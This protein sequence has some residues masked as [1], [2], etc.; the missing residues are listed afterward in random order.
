M[1]RF[2]NRKEQKYAKDFLNNNYN[3]LKV[4]LDNSTP[5]KKKKNLDSIKK[6]LLI[7]YYKSNHTKIYCYQCQ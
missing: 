7:F 2:L 3:F 6:N 5:S 1:G 4:F